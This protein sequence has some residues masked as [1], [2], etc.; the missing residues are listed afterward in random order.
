MLLSLKCQHLSPLLDRGQ[1]LSQSLQASPYD[2]V[3]WFERGNVLLALGLVELAMGDFFKA[4]LLC[5]QAGAPDSRHGYHVL[6]LLGRRVFG[7]GKGWCAAAIADAAGGADGVA[8]LGEFVRHLRLSVLRALVVALLQARCF[9]DAVR[10]AEGALLL[11][12][13][14]GAGAAAAVVE[15]GELRVA[16]GQLL[17]EYAVEYRGLEGD[18][19]EMAMRFGCVYRRVYPWMEE[20]HLRFVLPPFPFGGSLSRVGLTSAGDLR[21]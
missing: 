6:A 15:F 1:I 7:G 3:L 17:E 13:E 18:A 5:S 4:D 12:G 10:V 20:S 19:R 9:L 21:R 8:L 14:G 2:P 16:C 11:A